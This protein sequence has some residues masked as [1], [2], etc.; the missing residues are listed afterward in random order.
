M[1]PTMFATKDQA[2]KH[3]QDNQDKQILVFGADPGSLGEQ[4]RHIA[5]T[6]SIFSFHHYDLAKNALVVNGA[7]SDR[8][9]HDA[10]GVFFDEIIHLARKHN[11]W[12]GGELS[13]GEALKA[14]EFDLSLDGILRVA[15][16]ED[17]AV[18]FFERTLKTLEIDVNNVSSKDHEGFGYVAMQLSE[19]FAVHQERLLSEQLL[20]V[21]N[22]EFSACDMLLM[23]ID[24]RPSESIN[25]ERSD[26]SLLFALSNDAAFS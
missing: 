9:W 3:L 19:I 4:K 21:S 8:F 24:R 11:E 12:H 26:A 13:F 15:L 6:V 25:L 16:G 17:G 7:P 23:V 22:Y 10:A 1:L 2:R 18:R 14:A 5:A 20:D